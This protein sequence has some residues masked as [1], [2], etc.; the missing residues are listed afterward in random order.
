MLWC[1]HTELVSAW[2]PLDGALEDSYT[3]VGTV[4]VNKKKLHILESL[5][6]QRLGACLNIIGNTIYR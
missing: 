5:R 6:Q 3:I 1:K 2:M 4:V